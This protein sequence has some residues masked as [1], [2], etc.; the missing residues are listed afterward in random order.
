MRRKTQK[1]C[2]HNVKTGETWA[3]GEKKQNTKVLV[4]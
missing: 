4:Q 1:S 2:G 3:E